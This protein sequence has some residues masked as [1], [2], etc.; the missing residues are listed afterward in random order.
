[1]LRMMRA[2]AA[3]ESMFIPRLRLNKRRAECTVKAIQEQ[4][5]GFPPGLRVWATLYLAS[6]GGRRAGRVAYALRS[7]NLPAPVVGAEWQ[8]DSKFNAAE[9]LLRDPSLKDVIKVAIDK[10]VEVI[11]LK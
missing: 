7:G 4:T 8:I 9:E 2:P 11:Y 5:E 6:V 3:A 1:M 10:G